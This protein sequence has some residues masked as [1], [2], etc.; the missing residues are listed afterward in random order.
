MSNSGSPPAEPGVYLIAINY[1]K[2]FLFRKHST[3][4][5]KSGFKNHK[6]RLSIAMSLSIIFNTLI[7]F[8]LY[9][10]TAV[11]KRKALRKALRAYSKLSVYLLMYDPTPDFPTSSPPS[12]TILPRR[13]V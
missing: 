11:V 4:A 5:Q 8:M 7:H 9:E 10:A 1:C 6:L 12:T 13:T 3:R 2:L